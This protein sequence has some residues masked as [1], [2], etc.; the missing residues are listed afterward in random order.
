MKGVSVK[1]EGRTKGDRRE[2]VRKQGKERELTGKDYRSNRRV[3]EIRHKR[4]RSE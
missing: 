4:A 2:R 3:G 1:G